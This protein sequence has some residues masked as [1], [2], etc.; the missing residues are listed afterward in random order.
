MALRAGSEG[1]AAGGGVEP[2]YLAA[3]GVLLFAIAFDFFVTHKGV[4]VWERS[5]HEA[6]SVAVSRSD[7]QA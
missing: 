7:R 1:G 3:L 4:P 2:K 5:G 6:A